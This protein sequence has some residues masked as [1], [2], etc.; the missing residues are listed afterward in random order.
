M[1]KYFILPVAFVA[2]AAACNQSPK[3]SG[4]AGQAA[5]AGNQ[6]KTLTVD[7]ASS[8]VEWVGKRLAY[9][10]NG[11]FAIS[12]G[13]LAV[14]NGKITAGSFTID[15][16]SVVCLDIQDPTDNAKFVG[17]LKSDD[18]FNV[19]QFP[20]AKFEIIQV[21]EAPENP[22]YTHN[23]EGNLT[24]RDVTR[25]IYMPVNITM[26]E[27]GLTAA[28]NVVI[29]RTEWNVMWGS[30]NIVDW[31]KDKIVSNDVEIKVKLAANAA[32]MTA[33]N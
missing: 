22:D 16:N 26:T 20:T 2:F 21:M 30:A 9:S 11:T 33:S 23:I 29:N 25:K 13:S 32:E 17:H 31:T 10:H 7:A 24:I 3:T 14:D 8:A 15:I 28:G 5:E 4:E 19:E 27:N 18:F 1:R 6:A 12:N